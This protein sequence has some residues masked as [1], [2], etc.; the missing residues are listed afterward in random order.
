MSNRVG[1]IKE[2]WFITWRY[3]PTAQNPADVGSRGSS[4]DKIPDNWWNG[5]SWLS[6]SDEWP[7]DICTEPTKETEDESKKIKDILAVS[8]ENKQDTILEKYSLWKALRVKAWIAR[9]ITNFKTAVNQRVK[10]PLTTTEIEEQKFHLIKTAQESCEQADY[11]QE[12]QLQLNLQKNS[13][14]LYECRGRVQG[15]YPIYI[16]RESTL[17][18]KIAQ[19]AHLRTMHGGVSMTMAEIRKSYWIPKLRCLVKKIRKDCHGCK[20]FQVT[21]FADPPPGNLPLDRTV[22][23]RAFQVIGV[24]YAGPLYYKVG[25]NKERKAYVLLFACSLSR[26]VHLQALPRSNYRRSLSDQ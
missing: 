20:R 24:D 16:P 11:F 8:V 15:D 9:F 25:P 18:F 12:H 21:A 13:R 23:S 14:G 6:N 5:P 3:V 17:A 10:G 4:L 1:K 22:G 2:K 7:K 19:D 26:A